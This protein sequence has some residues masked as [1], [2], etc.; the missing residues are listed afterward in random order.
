MLFLYVLGKIFKSKVIEMLW[1]YFYKRLS[2]IM[3][4]IEILIEIKVG[5]LL[6][7]IIELIFECWNVYC[8][9]EILIFDRIEF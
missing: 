4:R 9:K 7:K 2:I 1:K 3:I 5:W 6:Y 8:E